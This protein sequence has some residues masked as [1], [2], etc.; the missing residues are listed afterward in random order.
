VMEAKGECM[1]ATAEALCNKRVLKLQAWEKKY[2]A[3]IEEL[4]LGEY[5]WLLKDCIACAVLVYTF[6]LAPVVISVL[7][8]GTCVLLGIPLTAG[9]ILSAIAT[10]GVL[11]EALSSFPELISVYAQTKVGTKNSH[12]KFSLGGLVD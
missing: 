12:M 11:Q 4:C 8:F 1:K 10:F 2:L 9:R 5:G 6:W 3:K 7:T